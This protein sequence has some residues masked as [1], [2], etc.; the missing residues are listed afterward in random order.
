MDSF[1]DI[2]KR[3]GIAIVEDATHAWEA[4]WNG[5]KIG[6]FGDITCFSLQGVNPTS[7]PI[8]GG[9]GG[10]VTTNNRKFYER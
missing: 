7:K 8:S 9:E 1:M 5:K 6:S 4:E 10:M 2:W 3:Y